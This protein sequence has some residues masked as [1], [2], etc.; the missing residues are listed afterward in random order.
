MESFTFEEDEIISSNTFNPDQLYTAFKKEIIILS[1]DGLK[2]AVIFFKRMKIIKDKM[3]AC[4]VNPIPLKLYD[5]EVNVVNTYASGQI[6]P[7]VRDTDFTLNRL[8]GCFARYVYDQYMNSDSSTRL[9]IQESI[10]N[11]LAIVKGVRADNF[12]LYMAF[13][14]GSEMFLDTFGL[15]PL[16]ITLRRIESDDAPASVLNKVLK[17]RLRGM[18]AI[19]WQKDST[20]KELKDAMVVVNSVSWKHSKISDESINFLKKAGVAAQTLNKIKKGLE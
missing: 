16:A 20:V 17:Q 15:L 19:D 3:K 5:V 8:S 4:Q 9:M 14:A 13:S 1:A 7:D 18:Q 2:A 12:K 10:K 6:M 11:P